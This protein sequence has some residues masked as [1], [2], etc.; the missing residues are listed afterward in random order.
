M[1][2]CAII[3]WKYTYPPNNLL[4]C[5]LT[6]S[7]D[8]KEEHAYESGNEQASRSVD[9][10]LGVART[11]LDGNDWRAKTCKTIQEARHSCSGTANRTWE[12]L[13]GISIKNPIHNVLE[14]GFEAG[15]G[16]LEVGIG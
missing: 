16:Q 14:E 12:Y 13:R 4:Q 6:P 10:G 1:N 15:K 11:S 3:S 5:L 9:R 2:L 8:R 7:L